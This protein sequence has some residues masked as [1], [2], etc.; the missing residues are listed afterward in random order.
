[1]LHQ[2][3]L[4]YNTEISLY[5]SSNVAYVPDADIDIV[6]VFCNNRTGTPRKIY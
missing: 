3:H 2:K 4:L 1:M 5:S 6:R